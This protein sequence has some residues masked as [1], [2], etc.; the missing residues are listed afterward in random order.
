MRNFA[1]PVSKTCLHHAF[2][3]LVLFHRQTIGLHFA[4][5]GTNDVLYLVLISKCN[6]TD[7][8]G[9]GR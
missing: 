9:T 3:L 4:C 2:S 5:G 6:D 1:E 7:N 8:Y